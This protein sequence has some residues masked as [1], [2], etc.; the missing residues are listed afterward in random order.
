L[1]PSCEHGTPPDFKQNRAWCI[2]TARLENC[3]KTIH[4]SPINI[5]LAWRLWVKDKPIEHHP[6]AHKPRRQVRRKIGFAPAPT[7]RIR[8]AIAQSSTEHVPSPP[9]AMLLVGGQRQAKCH[10]PTIEE[11][12]SQ[13]ESLMGGRSV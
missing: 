10:E 4:F 1:H 12:E 13:F 11:G 7:D 2:R 6:F 3:R 9:M 8:K 5:P